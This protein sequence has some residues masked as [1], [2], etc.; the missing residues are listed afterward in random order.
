M[1]KYLFL[2]L[3]AIVGMLAFTSCGDD[4]DD[5]KITRPDDEV[6]VEIGKAKFTEST[7]QMMLTFTIKIENISVPAKTVANFQ[8]DKCTSF[9][10]EYT[11]P[12]EAMAKQ[13]CEENQADADEYDTTVY[14]YSGKVYK[15]DDTAEYEG[16]SKAEIR[17]E[18]K[19]MESIFNSGK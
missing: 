2:C 12:S 3:A 16:K 7:N 8:G 19:I 6:N 18:L 14:S 13:T 10:T 17:Q 9:Y 1:K 11:F 5:I 15:E 4:E